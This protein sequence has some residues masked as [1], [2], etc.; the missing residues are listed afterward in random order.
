MSTNDN[1][2]LKVSTARFYT[3]VPG[4]ARPI[5]YELL[6]TPASPWKEVGHTTLDN[7]VDLTFEGGERTTLPT[8]QSPAVRESIS[9]VIES[10]AINLL[11]WTKESFELYYG[12]N[13]KVAADGAFEIP[14]VPQPKEVA[15]LV[16]LE[17][18]VSVAGFYAAK[19]SA[20]RTAAVAVADTS[21]LS[22]LPI[23]LTAMQMDG[24]ASAITVIPKKE[25]TGA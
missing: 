9:A 7:I 15:F 1:A 4:T 23:K 16:V 17:D 2:V 3:A 18:G 13:V 19:A 24:A 8:L 12:A 25:K 20:F 21:S 22:Q 5:T 11:E 10:F 6:K 14:S